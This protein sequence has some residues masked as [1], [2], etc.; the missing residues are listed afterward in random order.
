M[1]KDP[2]LTQHQNVFTENMHKLGVAGLIAGV[3]LFGGNRIAS[4]FAEEPMP[5]ANAAQGDHEYS[6]T[7]WPPIDQEIDGKENGGYKET[8]AHEAELCKESKGIRGPMNVVIKSAN[9]ADDSVKVNYKLQSLRDCNGYGRRTIK[10]FVQTKRPGQNDFKSGKTEIVRNHAP[11]SEK[12]R[13]DTAHACTGSLVTRLV[14]KVTWE[15]LDGS[16][17]KMTYRTPAKTVIC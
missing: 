10:M 12:E 14:S 7:E 2:S 11:V 8:E 15:H 13:M 16:K 3:A 17:S 6:G 4:A 5:R 1:D 9:R